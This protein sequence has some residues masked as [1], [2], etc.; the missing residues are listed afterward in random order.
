MFIE[1]IFKG[2]PRTSLVKKNILYSFLIK[3]WSCIIQLLLVPLTLNCLNQ[4]EYGIWL[5]INSILIWIDSFDIGLG[6]GLRNKL[7][8]SIAINDIHKGQI[9]ISTTF[10]MLIMIMVPVFIAIYLFITY[11][12]CHTLLN[13]NPDI[14][15]NLNGILILSFAIICMTFV[16]KFIG[17]IYLGLQLPAINNLLIVSG[18][19]VS[20][21]GIAILSKTEVSSLYSV[22]C[23]YTLSPLFVYIIS[24]PITFTKYKYL[25]PRIKLFD[26]TELKGLFGLGINFFMVQLAGIVIFSSSNVLISNL[27]SPS[28]VTP[29]QISYRYFS[30]A[31]MIFTIIAAPLWSATTDAYSHKDMEWIKKTLRRMRIVMLLFFVCIG[32]ML[33][34]SQIAYTIWIGK[35]INITWEMSTY[36]ALYIIILIYSTCY[37]NML[38]GIGKIR[39]ITII[40]I[41]EAIIYIPLAIYLSKHLGIEGVVLALITVN[42]I[43]AITNNIQLNKL[44][45]GKADGIWNK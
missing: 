36:M 29:Y 16:F 10:V 45:T 18:Q 3:G 31:I 11:N 13:V 20:L 25:R 33:T 34:L 24:Y 42:I 23:I 43:C 1:K 14:I 5:T 21:I 12:N 44:L 22:A 9:Q 41:I 8:E 26:K 15:P 28:E 6:N 38:F 37:S 30:L 19:T 17:N 32:I 2:D 40:T 27:F 39:L 35:Q 7:A 4:Y